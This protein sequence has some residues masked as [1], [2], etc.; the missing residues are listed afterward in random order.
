M[1]TITTEKAVTVSINSVEPTQKK[2][3]IEKKKQEKKSKELVEWGYNTH[4]LRVIR[5]YIILH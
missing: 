4:Y 3:E 1:T 2:R 5:Y